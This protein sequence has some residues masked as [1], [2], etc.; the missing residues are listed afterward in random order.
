MDFK[1]KTYSGK[2]IDLLNTRVSDIEITDIAKGLSNEPRWS[3]Q[4]E[5]HYSVASHSLLVAGRFFK[6]RA[7][8]IA[9]LHD[10][11]EAYIKDIPSPLKKLLP[12]YKEIE[13]RL[14]RVI[15]ERFNI[16]EVSEQE[17]LDIKTVD[18]QIR[19][20]EYEKLFVDKKDILRTGIH[21]VF[22][23]YKDT[24][25]ETYSKYLNGV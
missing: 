12:E 4:T 24:L 16:G 5:Y 23:K 7:K 13:K 21:T 18:M 10:S 6:P 2:E 22:K 14:C 11:P 9:L 17:R 8:L 3:G 15:F 1:I 25:T 20:Y 19:E